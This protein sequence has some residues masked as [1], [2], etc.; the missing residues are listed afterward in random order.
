M[1]IKS[2]RV[3]LHAHAEI[4]SAICVID[5]LDE[6]EIDAEIKNVKSRLIMTE[7]LLR[8]KIHGKGV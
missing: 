4:M 8:E 2:K 5:E 6:G 7:R 1:D 3:L